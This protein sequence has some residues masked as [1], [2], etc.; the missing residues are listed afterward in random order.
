MSTPPEKDPS[1]YRTY[2]IVSMIATDMAVTVVGGLYVGKWLDSLWGT[3]PWLMLAG[4]ILGLVA[5]IMGII[6]ITKR[7]S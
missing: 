6:E 4:I 2:G 1:P 7:F 5:G 3:S